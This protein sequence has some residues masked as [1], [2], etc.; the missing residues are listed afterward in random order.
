MLIADN[1]TTYYNLFTIVKFQIKI[2]KQSKVI[3]IIFKYTFVSI[4]Y[5]SVNKFRQLCFTKKYLFKKIKFS[6]NSVTNYY[7]KIVYH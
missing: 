5:S 7:K 1:I 4:I 2:L 3:I 6:R